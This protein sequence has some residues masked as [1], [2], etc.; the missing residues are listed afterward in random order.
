MFLFIYLQWENIRN[1]LYL[2]PKKNFKHFFKKKKEKKKKKVKKGK[3]NK[4][5]EGGNKK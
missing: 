5:G 4:K 1:V 2:L 3:Q